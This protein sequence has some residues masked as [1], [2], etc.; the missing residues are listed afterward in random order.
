MGRVETGRQN[1]QAYERLLAGTWLLHR[2][3]EGSLTRDERV[4][5][6]A[7]SYCTADTR[8]HCISRAR[9]KCRQK[10]WRSGEFRPHSLTRL[11]DRCESS[12]CSAVSQSTSV[13]SYTAI[14]HSRLSSQKPQSWR[15]HSIS[16]RITTSI[17]KTTRSISVT[18]RNNMKCTWSRVS[19][20]LWYAAPLFAS[21]RS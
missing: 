19:T 5:S 6:F 8:N 3:A 18:F 2:K 21:R 7:R 20:P 11:D 16:C 15:P 12:P 13:V 1:R 4:V 10:S 17:P 14:A 9:S